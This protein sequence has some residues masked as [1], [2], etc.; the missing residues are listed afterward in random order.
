M[1]LRSAMQDSEVP[2]IYMHYFMVLQCNV[3]WYAFQCIP[4]HYSVVHLRSVRCSAFQSSTLQCISKH[5]STVHHRALQCSTSQN[6]TDQC[7]S[8]Q[9]STVN[10]RAVQYS[11][12]QS[13]TVQCICRSNLSLP[14][15]AGCQL[16]LHTSPNP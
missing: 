3:N 14:E 11:A 7:I 10:L 9:Y 6:S 2:G 13:S 5:Y 12:S 8:E 4:E 1:V 16:P 15:S